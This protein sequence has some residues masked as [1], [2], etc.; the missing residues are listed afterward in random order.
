MSLNQF[1]YFTELPFDIQV[2]IL[3][4]YDKKLLILSRSLNKNLREAS[5][6]DFL[7]NEFMRSISVKEFDNF[8]EIF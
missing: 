7:K 2:N 8:L 3:R 4:N 1:L 6:T 5:Y